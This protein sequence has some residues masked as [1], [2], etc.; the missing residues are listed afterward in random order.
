[1]PLSSPPLPERLLPEAE[2]LLPEVLLPEVL[3]PGKLL[4]LDNCS[5]NDPHH[6]QSI[7]SPSHASV[8]GILPASD[9]F[10]CIDGKHHH[11]YGATLQKLF[12]DLD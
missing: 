6:T 9:L 1:M 4:L 2:V 3:L 5:V 12:S 7:S 10:A 8:P 11:N